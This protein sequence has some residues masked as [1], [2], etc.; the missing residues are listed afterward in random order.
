[1]MSVESAVAV[2]ITALFMIKIFI[3]FRSWNHRTV[4]LFSLEKKP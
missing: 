4:E 2:G 3:I 1:M